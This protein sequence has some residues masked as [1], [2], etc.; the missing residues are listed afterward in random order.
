MYDVQ[1]DLDEFSKEFGIKVTNPIHRASRLSAKYRIMIALREHY[2]KHRNI[3]QKI[4]HEKQDEKYMLNSNN[5]FESR[6]YRISCAAELQFDYKNGKMIAPYIE[7]ETIEI[8]DML[9]K[10]FLPEYK[11]K[12]G[13]MIRN[14]HIV[15]LN[16]IEEANLDEYKKVHNSFFRFCVASFSFEEGCEFAKYAS[17]L[18]IEMI[19]LSSSFVGIVYKFWINK[20]WKEKVNRLCIEDR[21]MHEFYSGMDK[22]KIHE[23]R[24]ISKGSNPGN[25]YKEKI[26]A[27][28]L[29]EI[30]YR[31]T[32]ELH[33]E[34]EMVIFSMSQKAIAFNI[35]KT[36]IDGNTSKE[37]WKSIGIDVRFCNFLLEQDACIN[38]LHR[39]NFDLDYIYK[40]NETDKYDSRIIA[41]EIAEKFSEYLCVVGLKN[42]IEEKITEISVWVQR[43]KKADF[44][45]WL[46]IKS[47]VD[48]DLMYATRFVNEFKSRGYLEPN[49]YKVNTGVN[50][51]ESANDNLDITIE[52]CK[53]I[54][55]DVKRI[56][57]SNV[58][59]RN[60]TSS[61]KIQK[62]TFY[63]N[64]CSAIF[65]LV[66]IGIS[67]LSEDARIKVITWMSDNMILKG[68]LV[69]SIVFSLIY[70][71][72]SIITGILNYCR[73]M[74][75]F[76]GR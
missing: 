71:L 30:K 54:I 7:L 37:F 10:E 33:R 15:G 59:A 50:I 62:I 20:E 19:S 73:R 74:Y 35:F 58:E 42:A 21:D 64:L 4:I 75:V 11:Q 14:H 1:I 70:M 27:V 45:T 60:S 49:D 18:N 26:L 41:Y 57:D 24:R 52:H 5:S 40:I 65:A 25:I 28:L 69:F 68:V 47:S 16:N 63:T 29:E 13:K 48:N 46:K 67:L 51:A 72:K 76:K 44:N 31:L 22:L 6:R 2:I 34:F 55:E 43:G 61:Y 66:A 9:P 36:N 56:V 38:P 17:G 12:I 8:V 23:F 3:Y 39:E 53:K 32:K